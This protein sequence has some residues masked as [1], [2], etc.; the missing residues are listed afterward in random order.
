MAGKVEIRKA[1]LRE[2]LVVIAEE[3]IVAGGFHSV[4]ARH[5]A[6]S[7]GC[8]L[9]AIYNVFDDINALIMV[10]N[11]RTFHKIGKTVSAAVERSKQDTPNDQLIEMSN[12]Y[13]RFAADNT[14][15]WLALFELKMP[16]DGAV[17]EWYLRE[18]S[19]LFAHISKPLAVLFPDMER[20][21]LELM[22][23]ALFSAVH[24]IVLLGLE[25]RISGVPKGQV[26]VMIAQVLGQIGNKK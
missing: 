15:L 22:T 6:A 1:K 8:A 25:N 19:Q 24:G 20:G 5:L 23:R 18:L 26:E 21:E 13:L 3:Q 10:V 12:A 14:H 7:A 4:K 11:G 9:G 16:A 17:P 2:A